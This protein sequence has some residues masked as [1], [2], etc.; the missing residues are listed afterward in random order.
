MNKDLTVLG[1]VFKSVVDLANTEFDFFGFSISPLDI[2]VT[3][4][5]IAMLLDILLT[6]AGYERTE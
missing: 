3:N 4:L 5:T 2:L 6:Y 1:D